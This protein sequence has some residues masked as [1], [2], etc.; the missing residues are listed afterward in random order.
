MMTC[1]YKHIVKL[2]YSNEGIYS[3]YNYIPVITFTINQSFGVLE[4]ITMHENVV[5]GRLF[6]HRKNA[7]LVYNYRDA[8]GMVI[9][10]N[11]VPGVLTYGR[12]HC[13]LYYFV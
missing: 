4:I 3:E 12:F 2:V 10:S 7:M 9:T 8:L 11:G 13:R 1:G 5:L 6:C